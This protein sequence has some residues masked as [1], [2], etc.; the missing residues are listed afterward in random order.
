VRDVLTVRGSLETRS[1]KGGTAPDRVTEQL[2]RLGEELEAARR[3]SDAHPLV[4]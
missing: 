3:W 2:G 4:R 1:A